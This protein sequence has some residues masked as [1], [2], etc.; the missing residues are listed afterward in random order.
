MHASISVR[1]KNYRLP[2][3]PTMNSQV[4]NIVSDM[5]ASIPLR[6]ASSA[7]QLPH[8]IIILYAKRKTLDSSSSSSST[9]VT[10]TVYVSNY[11]VAR[12]L[13]KYNILYGVH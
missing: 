1:V 2:T 7:I 10:F 5:N 4:K 13:N 3:N 11:D 12:K 6:H 9:E 8:E